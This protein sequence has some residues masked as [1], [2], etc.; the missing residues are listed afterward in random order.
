MKPELVRRNYEQHISEGIRAE[1]AYYRSSDIND[2][3][4]RGMGRGR[5]GSGVGGRGRK[6]GKGERKRS[7]LHS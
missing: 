2:K 1:V 4:G 3:W 5:G 6:E 7:Y